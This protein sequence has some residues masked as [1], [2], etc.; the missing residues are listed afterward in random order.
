[1]LV[2]GRFESVIVQ[3]PESQTPLRNLS[4]YEAVRFVV[5][6]R[7]TGPEAEA[8]LALPAGQRQRSFQSSDAISS[9]FFLAAYD[10]VNRG[11]T[12]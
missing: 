7:R 9:R 4:R 2:A 12:G 3:S 5:A 6:V 10:S 1:M 8:L 11:K